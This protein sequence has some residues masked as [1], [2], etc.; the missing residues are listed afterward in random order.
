MRNLK[1]LSIAILLSIAGLFGCVYF[2]S[3]GEIGMI[4]TIFIVIV[5]VFIILKCQ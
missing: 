2:F 3:G 5:I 4:I 1:K